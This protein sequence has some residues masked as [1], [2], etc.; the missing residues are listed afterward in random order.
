MQLLFVLAGFLAQITNASP[1]ARANIPARE[2]PLPT[3]P[4]QLPNQA[5]QIPGETPVWTIGT[6][7]PISTHLPKQIMLM[8]SL[9]CTEDFWASLLTLYLTP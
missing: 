8:V 3:P 4:P 5:R 7:T 9:A 1:H 6:S 2:A